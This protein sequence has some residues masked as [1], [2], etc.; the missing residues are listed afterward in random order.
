ML[1]CRKLYT[2]IDSLGTIFKLF[3]KRN[4]LLQSEGIDITEMKTTAY[5]GEDHH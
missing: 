2:A 5:L 3:Q 1:R 4:D